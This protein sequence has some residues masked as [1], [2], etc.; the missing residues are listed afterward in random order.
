MCINNPKVNWYKVNYNYT[1]IKL[2]KQYIIFIWF[3]RW[4]LEPKL[5]LNPNKAAGCVLVISIV[6]VEL[7]MNWRHDGFVMIFITHFMVNNNAQMIY[8]GK[9]LTKKWTYD[10]DNDV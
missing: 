1:I 2:M 7:E 4:T 5:S 6:Q 3:Y 9:F 8:Y 10:V